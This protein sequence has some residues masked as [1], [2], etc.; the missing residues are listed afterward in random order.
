MEGT[1]LVT[2]EQL[3]STANEFNNIMTQVQ[4]LTNNMTDQINGM[5][6]KWQGEAS[7]AYINKFNQLQED[8]DRLARMINEHVTDLNEMASLY[9]TTE[10]KNEDLG[11]SLAADIL[12]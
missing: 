6:A 12:V 5:G 8:I 9:R 4:N 2:P 1:I 3:E 7:T 11:N 10:Q